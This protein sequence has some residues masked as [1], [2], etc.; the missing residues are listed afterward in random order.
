MCWRTGG[1]CALMATW[2]VRSWVC[3][4]AEDEQAMSEGG[5]M[6]F[7]RRDQDNKQ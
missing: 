7:G 6:G 3:G 5:W 4:V 2:L 1:R